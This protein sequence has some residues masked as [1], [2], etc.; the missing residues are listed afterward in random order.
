VT[1]SKTVSETS[2]KHIRQALT[3]AFD[4]RGLQLTFHQTCK[5]YQAGE[6]EFLDGNHWITSEDDYGFVTKDLVK[7]TSEGKQL[8]VNRTNQMRHLSQQQSVSQYD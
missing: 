6:V 8:T 1:S 3:S 7:P 5:A 4:N 2:N